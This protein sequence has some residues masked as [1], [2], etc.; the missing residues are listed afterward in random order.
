MSCPSHRTAALAA[1]ALAL[2][3]PAAL[4]VPP[5]PSDDDVQRMVDAKQYRPAA[6][7]LQ[8]LVALRGRSAEHNDRGRD[9]QLL[10]E[11]QLQLRQAAPLARTLK[12]A[13]DHALEANDVDALGEAATLEL[14]RRASIDLVYSPRA[15]RRAKYDLTDPARRKAA[16]PLVYAESLAA[17]TEAWRKARA[18]RDLA[19]VVELAG[20]FAL[21]RGAE[22]A[23]TGGTAETDKLGQ[24]LERGAGRL[25]DQ[26][27]KQLSDR[28]ENDR[29]RANEMVTTQTLRARSTGNFGSVRHRR[30]LSASD[31]AEVRAIGAECVRIGKQVDAINR[32][33]AAPL[34]LGGAEPT[35]DDVRQKAADLLSDMDAQ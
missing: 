32:G 18:G 26:R 22:Y 8:R 13:V 6:E 11:C 10:A 24:D 5:L 21:V 23:T 15:D 31:A 14:L 25:V 17:V 12:D 1:A 3:T 20:R 28:L 33:M 30:G 34:Q 2:F 27:L 19:P 35:A 29:K 4:A 7:Q 16:G 9:L